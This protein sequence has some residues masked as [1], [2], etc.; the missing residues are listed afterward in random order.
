MG[1]AQ[2][3][4][5]HRRNLPLHVHGTHEVVNQST[6]LSGHDAAEADVALIG[7]VRLFGGDWGL[8]E[9][10][11]LGRRTPATRRSSAGASWP[12][13]TSPSCIGTTASVIASTSSSTTLPTTR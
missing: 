5:G 4:T 3:A 11:C 9:L 2:I 6:P 13:R 1:E 10:S 8:A 7:G 12:T